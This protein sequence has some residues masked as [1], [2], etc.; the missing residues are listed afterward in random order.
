MLL[1]KTLCSLS[2][3]SDMIVVALTLERCIRVQTDRKET[4]TPSSDWNDSWVYR[5]RASRPCLDSLF[6]SVRMP[7][8]SVQRSPFAFKRVRAA[9]RDKGVW[10]RTIPVELGVLESQTTMRVL[11][12]ALKRPPGRGAPRVLPWVGAKIRCWFRRRSSEDLSSSRL[13]I[14]LLLLLLSRA[15]QSV[16]RLSKKRRGPLRDGSCWNPALTLIGRR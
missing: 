13:D 14:L 2:D 1:T 15:N 12:L 6:E 5:R 10:P 16:A 3:A 9:S 8:T 4:K 7:N 11:R